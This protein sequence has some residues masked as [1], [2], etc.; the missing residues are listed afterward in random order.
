MQTPEEIIEGQA[1]RYVDSWQVGDGAKTFALA[2]VVAL[3][4]AGHH[5]SHVD[6]RP[7]ETHMDEH[8]PSDPNCVRHRRELDEGKYCR[9]CVRYDNAVWLTQRE[10]FEAS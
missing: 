1:I 9:I 8:E 2:V 3:R 7:D 6:V 10:I 5:F 4:E